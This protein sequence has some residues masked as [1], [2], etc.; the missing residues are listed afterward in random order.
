MW[1]SGVRL[2]L[3]C[4]LNDA[5]FFVG[6]VVELVDQLVDLPVCGVDLALDGPFFM[7]GLGD[8]DVF[9]KILDIAGQLHNPAMLQSVKG[10]SNPPLSQTELGVIH[11]YWVALNNRRRPPN[12]TDT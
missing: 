10:S 1:A 7:I 11:F 3:R 4:L 6:Q 9:L 5:D 12:A 2:S 8:L